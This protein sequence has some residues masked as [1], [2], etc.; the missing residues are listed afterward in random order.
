MLPVKKVIAGKRGAITAVEIMEACAT[1]LKDSR[2]RV[3]QQLGDLVAVMPQMR[4][5]A[6]QINSDDRKLLKSIFKRLADAK[7][8][9]ALE[10]TVS[11]L[12]QENRGSQVAGLAEGIRAGKRIIS[13]G[14]ST[15]YDDRHPYYQFAG[16]FTTGQR[17]AR[18][19]KEIKGVVSA[20]IAGAIGGA[21]GGAAA[22]GIG[23]GPGAIGGGLIASGSQAAMNVVNNVLGTE[24]VEL[25]E[26][27]IDK[28]GGGK[29]P[30]A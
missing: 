13:S 20:D 19:A 26:D 5:S 8:L 30:P 16:T 3:G 2:P 15:V 25:F 23:A 27:I 18:S 9:D 24:D 6:E 28:Y 21:F 7:N 29:F 1:V 14:K 4:Q 22:G 10:R 12:D 11:L 17:I